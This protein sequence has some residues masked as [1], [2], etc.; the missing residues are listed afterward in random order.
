M[1]L[2]FELMDLRISLGVKK[3]LNKP[4][5]KGFREGAELSEIANRERKF[6]HFLSIR[7][8]ALADYVGTNG[9]KYF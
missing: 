7:E 4:D 2:A 1:E 9:L 6:N 5:L 3:S 8:K